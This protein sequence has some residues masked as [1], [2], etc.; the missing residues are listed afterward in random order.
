MPA[1][2]IPFTS[3]E[4]Y[5]KKLY[6]V[7]VTELQIGP[8][9]TASAAGLLVGY[10]QDPCNPDHRMYPELDL[11]D[12]GDTDGDTPSSGGG[13]GTVTK[14]EHGKAPINGEVSKDP[15]R[16]TVKEGKLPQEVHLIKP[17]ADHLKDQYLNY[18]I[19]VTYEQDQM[20]F[21][22]PI[23][24]FSESGETQLAAKFAE[25]GFKLASSYATS[26]TEPRVRRVVVVNATRHN[27][28]PVLPEPV[29]VYTDGNDIDC[30]LLDYTISPSAP[31][32]TATGDGLLYNSQATYVYGLNQAPDSKQ[33]LYEIGAVPW[34][35][36]ELGKGGTAF[37][38]STFQKTKIAMGDNKATATPDDSS[39]SSSSEDDTP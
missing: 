8:H 39:D 24:A 3:S 36:M 5:G 34:T 17:A 21:W 29:K 26:L 13:T 12:T 27:Q 20:N 7:D 11:S 31:V 9:G 38:A 32:P 23:S 19:E 6:N 10:L 15:P 37:K 18:D 14:G 1:P 28:P 30:H 16:I 2:G 4:R 33:N 25:A 35:Q 22:M